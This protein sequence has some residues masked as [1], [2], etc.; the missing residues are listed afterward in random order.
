MK[1]FTL[2][3]HLAEKLLVDTEIGANQRAQF[4]QSL[5]SNNTHPQ[6]WKSTDGTDALA[7]FSVLCGSTATALSTI[8]DNSWVFT[9]LDRCHSKFV[10]ME[11]DVFASFDNQALG[12]GKICCHKVPVRIVC[13][14]TRCLFIPLCRC[15]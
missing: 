5:C 15:L 14:A 10:L 6:P 1:D 8:G 4:P 7:D 2:M 11:Q 13:N 12:T 9:L 3:A